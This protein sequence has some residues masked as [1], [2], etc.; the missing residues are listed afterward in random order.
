MKELNESELKNISGG[1]GTT[2]SIPK[3]HT[4]VAGDN[5]TNIA[6]KY[7]IKSWKVI[8]DL[9]KDLIDSDAKKHGVKKDFQNYVSHGQVLKLK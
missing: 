7:G 5:L 2:K 3:T 9:N 6:K 1:A 4:V 8:Y